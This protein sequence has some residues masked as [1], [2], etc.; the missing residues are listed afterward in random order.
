MKTFLTTK[1]AVRIA[2]VLVAAAVLAGAIFSVSPVF[3]QTGTS[4][5][6]APSAADPAKL[7]AKLEKAYQTELKSLDALQKAV[8]R[9][10]TVEIPKVQDRIN[11][12]KA[13]GRDTTGLETALSTFQAQLP[14]VQSSVDSAAAVLNTHAGFD[15][16]GKVTAAAQAAQTVRNVRQS[17]VDGR[18]VL[19]QA[20]KDL[21]QAGRSFRLEDIRQ[22]GALKQEQ[23]RLDRLQNQLT[24]TDKV[25]TRSQAFINQQKQAGKDTSTLENALKVF[26]SQ[27]VN[28][29]TAHDTAA[30]VLT[31]HAGFD[32]QGQVTD[33]AAARQTLQAA[34]QALAN[35]ETTLR[36]ARR[37]LAQ[38]FAP[39]KNA[40]PT[41]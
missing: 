20:Q 25:V 15:A 21:T 38:A 34:R 3:A 14:Q 8:D 29:K 2:A 1:I 11:Q 41:A 39:W 7:D 37:D 18:R 16:S 19:K 32:D 26:Q 40:N 36:Q 10:K 6:T 33:A 28:V 30:A 13:K 22:P 5:P 35:G 27:V 24:R 9:V 31:Q 17:L 12:Q 23:Q 4:T